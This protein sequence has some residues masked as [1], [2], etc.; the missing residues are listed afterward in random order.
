MPVGL[1]S[2][3]DQLPF[4]DLAQRPA[5]SLEPNLPDR[6]RTLL[7]PGWA[8]SV[9]V[10]RVVAALLVVLAA[11]FA[12]RNDPTTEHTAVVIAARDLTPGVA[13]TADDVEFADRDTSTLVTGTLTDVADAIGHTL[14]GPVP[15]G[16]AL[17]DTRL[18]GP[19]LAAAAVGVGADDARVVPIR[20][21]DAGVG[22][23]LREGDRV[24][25]LTVT[26]ESDAAMGDAHVLA[27][28]AVVVLAQHEE[29]SDQRER[30]IL[31]A[32]EQEQAMSVAAASL[33]SALTVTL[34]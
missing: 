25:V 13:L 12:L 9:A 34:H 7:S 26:A 6:I 32:L 16:E 18:L 33:T 17:V 2:F 8:R 23:L 22:R 4:R 5:S 10:R 21:A 29:S 30:V 20:L 24:D 27:R 14:A 3:R 1:S 11:I 31:V 19:R 15:A 28:G